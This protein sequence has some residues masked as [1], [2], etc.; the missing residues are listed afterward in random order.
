MI[1]RLISEQEGVKWSVVSINRP[2]RSLMSRPS[3][4][5]SAFVYIET[6]GGRP[7][8]SRT[9][10]TIPVILIGYA[11]E[12]SPGSITVMDR[13]GKKYLEPGNPALGD[14]S[15]NR[16][17]E[18]EI[19]EEILGEARLDQGSSGVRAGGDPARGAT[20]ALEAAW[21]PSRSQAGRWH[22]CASASRRSRS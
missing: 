12:L 5:A 4:K 18:E 13:R 7:L 10:Q 9:V 1:E 16:V 14:N 21:C 20:T 6:E 19:S 2:Y 15:R 3:S 8:P 11:P 17:R 22:C